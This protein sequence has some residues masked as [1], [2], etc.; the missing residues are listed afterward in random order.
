MSIQT[1]ALI[2]KVSVSPTHET[3]QVSAMAKEI[4]DLA[5]KRNAVVHE[6]ELV[7]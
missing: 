7:S 1:F 5:G 4:E 6:G 2:V 3:Y